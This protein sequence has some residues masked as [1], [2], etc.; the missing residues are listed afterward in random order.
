MND[1]LK[2]QP[3]QRQTAAFGLAEIASAFSSRD[4][5]GDDFI[6]KIRRGI[7]HLNQFLNEVCPVPE[8]NEKEAELARNLHTYMRKYMDSS[9]SCMI[10]QMIDDSLGIGVWYS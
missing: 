10:Y 2:I 3:H 6:W 4:D 7:S 5:C 8:L 9:F 1:K